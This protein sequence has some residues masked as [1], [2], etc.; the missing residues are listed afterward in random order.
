ML[1]PGGDGSATGR[2]R[3]S[4]SSSENSLSSPTGGSTEDRSKMAKRIIDNIKK[5]PAL[6]II[7]SDMERV[8]GALIKLAYAPVNMINMLATI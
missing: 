7:A 1:V 5:K 8:C 4:T 6:S 2:R 3:A